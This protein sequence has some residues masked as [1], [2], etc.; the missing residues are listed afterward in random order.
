MKRL[1]GGLI[2]SVLL[3]LGAA[4]TPLN[5]LNGPA[6]WW[7][8]KG[9]VPAT[10]DFDFANGRYYQARTAQGQSSGTLI[11][12]SRASTG[13]ASNSSGI[14]SSFANNVA[15]I[16]NKGLLVEEARTN[17]ALWSRDLTNAAW[18]KVG[19]TAALNAVGIDNNANSATT[20]TAT[21]AAGVCTSSC[22]ALQTITLGSTADTYSVFLKRVTGTGTVNITINNLAGAT[23]C[24]L[25]TTA[26]TLCQVTATLANPVIGIQ[27]TTV[28]DII[29]ADFN[30]ME[31]GGFATSP[32][33]TTSAAVTRAAD[34]VTVTNPLVYGNAITAFS[35][36]IPQT[37][38]TAPTQ[39][40]IQIDNGSS[41]NNRLALFRSSATGTAAIV[42]GS[43]GTQTIETGAV[44]AQGAAGALAATTAA[45]NSQSFVFNGGAPITG[46]GNF[47][48]GSLT[49]TTIGSNLGTL[50]WN[51]YI[52]RV[53]V[54]A[55]TRQPDN[56][57]QAR[58]Q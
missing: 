49:S 46:A 41:T 12:T 2:L 51:G 58:T 34:A 32:I 35:A 10:I 15:R 42:N 52:P 5:V 6:P 25:T 37:P 24:T 8:L 26:F 45:P 39:A 44:W 21:G 16:T 9:T 17:D 28:G 11:S 22:T 1:A 36:G 40:A 29:V 30:Q 18:I 56:V 53:A 43:A 55:S 3:A 54:W 48:V 47:P 31:P 33:L 4:A 13:Y 50:F 27:M 57:L 23:G 38:T 19:A 7:V 14:Y 20:L